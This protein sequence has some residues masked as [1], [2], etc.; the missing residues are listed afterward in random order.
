M[1]AKDTVMSDEQIYTV[2]KPYA[3]GEFWV[4]DYDR[5]IA[6]AQAELSFKVGIKQVVEWVERNSE[7]DGENPQEFSVFPEMVWQAQKKDWGVSK[8]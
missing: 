7:S 4:V 8:E 2:G 6:K 1:E 3:D 5:G